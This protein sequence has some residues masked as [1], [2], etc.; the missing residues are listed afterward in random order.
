MN[1]TKVLKQRMRM[2]KEIDFTEDFRKRFVA[3][4]YGNYEKYDKNSIK[5]NIEKG[6]ND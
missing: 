2:E 6:T 4:E 5:N 1:T 3:K